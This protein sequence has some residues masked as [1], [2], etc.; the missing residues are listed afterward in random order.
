MRG[1]NYSVFIDGCRCCFKKINLIK[2]IKEI[3]KNI[4][5]A[6][7]IK[8][9]STHLNLL[10]STEVSLFALFCRRPKINCFTSFHI[11]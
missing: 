11:F 6:I 10:F 5:K 3:G 9:N 2:R 4:V 8:I 1:F 7:K